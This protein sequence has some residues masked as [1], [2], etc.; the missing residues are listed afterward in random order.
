MKNDTLVARNAMPS[1]IHNMMTTLRHILARGFADRRRWLARLLGVLTLCAMSGAAYALRPTTEYTPDE[2]ARGAWLIVVGMIPLAAALLLQRPAMFR[3]GA[4]VGYSGST[5]WVLVGGGALA[6]LVLTEASSQLIGLTVLDGMPHDLQ[7]A[8]L[9]GGAVLLGWGFGGGG[10]PW[11]VRHGLQR[12]TRQ[13]WNDIALV[14][15]VMVM[16]G[17]L[18]LFRLESG[19]RFFVDEYNFALIPPYFDFFDDVNVLSPFVRG[20]TA[21][22]SYFHHLSTNA[23]GD[24]L[25]GLRV[26]SVVF[27]T[28]TIPAAYLLARYLFDRPTALAALLIFA[29][30]PPHV[31][32]SRLALNNIADPLFGTFALAFLARAMR[33]NQQRDF[34]LGGVA[35]GLTQYFYEVGRLFYPLIVLTWCGWGLMMGYA[36]PYVRGLLLAA[37]VAV[38]VA[39]PVYA[40]YYADGVSFIPRVEEE[41]EVNGPAG[42]QG[43][44]E[45]AD[46][47]DDEYLKR[48]SV[49][50]RVYSN[51]TEIY[52]PY[53]GSQYGYVLLPLLPFFF[54]GIGV[55]CVQAWRLPIVL[56]LNLALVSFAASLIE[57]HWV[58]ARYVVTHAALAVLIAVGVRTLIGMLLAAWHDARLA[59]VLMATVW[60]LALAAALL[61][62][63][64]YHGA[65][66]RNFNAETRGA[67]DYDGQDAIFR[68]AA[69][70]EPVR[71][72][73]FSQRVLD[74]GLLDNILNYLKPNS[75]GLTV[76]NPSAYSPWLLA[77]AEN[78]VFFVP[79]DDEAGILDVLRWSYVL[80]TPEG[81]PD[82][83]LIPAGH[84]FALTRPLHRLQGPH[85]PP[86]GVNDR[87]EWERAATV[88]A[89][90][91][92]LDE[93]PW[94]SARVVCF[95]ARFARGIY[96]VWVWRAAQ[97]DT[98]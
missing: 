91:C 31:Q 66:T 1:P 13:D 16:A 51:A 86:W 5:N 61:Q 43:A 73:L 26:P 79:W 34:V 25:Y 83:D 6:L 19:M 78:H 85:M 46:F 11:D 8:L 68:A 20:F 76:W 80:S 94:I 57:T 45:R 22:F 44:L 55:V 77:P 17:G 82:T 12:L 90:H 15:L 75:H 4:R 97:L 9:M 42:I 64:Y 33:F 60:A 3:R 58:S 74:P 29:T 59:R 24:S 56:V 88:R 23:L 18:R 40:T 62:A 48:L 38:L 32:F 69:I 81:S 84:E 89:R 49:T 2:W 93:L 37:V 71:V 98:Q 14:G 87:A 65:H 95:D 54:L 92:A 10:L 72:H 39:L 35:L 47:A 36:R 21:T 41:A 52:T 7:M 30:F 67:H 53:Y 96:G 27:G 63:A 50:A 70:E 28:L